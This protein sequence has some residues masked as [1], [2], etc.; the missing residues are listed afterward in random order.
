MARDMITLSGFVPDKEIEVKYTGLRP[1]E[2]LY[3]ELITEGE[4]VIPTEHDDIMVLRPSE[5]LPAEVIDWHVDALVDRALE[6]DV[7]GLKHVL[8]GAVPEYCPQV[9]EGRGADAGDGCV[10]HFDWDRK[11]RM[12]N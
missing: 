6:M 8:R 10:I 3:E 7:Q 11:V 1:G 9:E 12:A 2:K 4:D 5:C